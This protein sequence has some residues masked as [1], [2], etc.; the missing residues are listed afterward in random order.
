MELDIKRLA[1]NECANHERKF[2]SF[3]NACLV[4]QNLKCVFFFED[5]PRCK[6]FEET[7]LPL[8][9]RLEAL[10]HADREARAYGSQLTK[11]RKRAI[12]EETAWVGKVRGK[13]ERCGEEFPAANNRQKYC[14]SCRKWVT[15][16]QARTRKQKQRAAG[17]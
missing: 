9:K 15:R 3:I 5:H 1:V 7:V 16:E 2:N 17:G 10:Y 6:Y 12:L 14:P 8:D 13:C 4:R 11:Q